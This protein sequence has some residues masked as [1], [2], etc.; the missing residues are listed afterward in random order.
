MGKAFYLDNT[1]CIITYCAC[2]LWYIDWATE[3]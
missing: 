1:I 3:N 2:K